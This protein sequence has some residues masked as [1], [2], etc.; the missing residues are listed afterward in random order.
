[1]RRKVFSIDFERTCLAG[2]VLNLLRALTGRLEGVGRLVDI[3]LVVADQRDGECVCA[4]AKEAKSAGCL[5]VRGVS[6]LVEGWRFPLQAFCMGLMPLVWSHARQV[7]NA[8]AEK[9]AGM[10][11]IAVDRFLNFALASG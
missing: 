10:V 9:L 11:V 1:M 4:R 3:L 6:D 2:S 7:S 8:A 5:V